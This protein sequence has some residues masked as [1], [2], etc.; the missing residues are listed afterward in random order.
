MQIKTGKV[1]IIQHRKSD[2]GMGHKMVAFGDD[3]GVDG[4]V[5]G[6]YPGFLGAQGWNQQR[7]K[8]RKKK[9]GTS[10][11]PSCSVHLKISRATEDK[12][13]RCRFSQ[14]S[15]FYT[16]PRKKEIAGIARNRPES[17]RNQSGR[18]SSNRHTSRLLRLIAIA[19][20]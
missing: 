17:Q 18:P 9:A 2:P 10:Q 15:C 8:E 20:G 13:V 4:V 6:F 7:Q 16:T 12:G 19:R 11:E 5:F 14:K 1:G 3:L